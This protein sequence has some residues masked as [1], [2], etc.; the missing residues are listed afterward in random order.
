MFYLL[1]R[2]INPL[3]MYIN[4]LED[5]WKRLTFTVYDIGEN[6]SRAG[7]KSRHFDECLQATN[8]ATVLC[9]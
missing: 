7:F 4:A 1:K 9:G 6:L 3:E 5:P 8:R 2:N